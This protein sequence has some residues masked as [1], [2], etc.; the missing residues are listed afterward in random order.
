MSTTTVMEMRGI[1]WSDS[2]ILQIS[3]LFLCL[4]CIFQCCM[5]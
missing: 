3:N 1:K 2:S 5:C 4:P